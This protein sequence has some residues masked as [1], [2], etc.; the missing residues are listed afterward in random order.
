MNR[1]KMTIPGIG[2]LGIGDTS[3]QPQSMED[4]LATLLAQSRIKEA[5]T[6]YNLT[7]TEGGTSSRFSGTGKLIASVSGA[8]KL[9]PYVTGKG[10]NRTTEYITEAERARRGPATIEPR[11]RAASTTAASGEDIADIVEGIKRGDRSADTSGYRGVD[12]TKIDARLLRE[13][14]SPSK[15]IADQ[16]ALQ[17]H[18][19]NLNSDG[20]NAL[21]VAADSTDQALTALEEL[22]NRW[23]DTVGGSFNGARIALAKRNGLGEA[24]KQLATDLEAAVGEVQTGLATIKTGG[25]APA[26]KALEAAEKSIAV[27]FA[28]GRTSQAIKS[29]RREVQHRVSAIKNLQPI[30]PSEAAGGGGGKAKTA[31]DVAAAL[32]VEGRANDDATVKKVMASPE[33]MKALFP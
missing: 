16:K 23:N 4:Q 9:V 30:L 15:A 26:N 28:A 24:A 11:P 32:K 22:S 20:F 1:P 17:Q 13:G 6:P 31:G 27:D 7:A 12:R 14:F 18:Y 3:A 25:S 2:E 29:I 10:G 21:R 19:S 8:E 5:T 33:A